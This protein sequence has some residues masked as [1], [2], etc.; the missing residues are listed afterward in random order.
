MSNPVLKS[1]KGRL[2]TFKRT[3]HNRDR[4][5]ILPVLHC[6]IQE[7]ISHKSGQD[8]RMHPGKR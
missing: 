1:A 3:L 6:S 5:P 2:L 8:P 7:G 4:G